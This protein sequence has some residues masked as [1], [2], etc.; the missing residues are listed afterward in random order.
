MEIMVLPLDQL[1]PAP[2]NP[3]RALKPGDAAFEKLK[4]SIQ[5]YS[6]IEPIIWNE[7]TGNIVGGHQRYAVLKDLGYKEAH[8]SVVHLTDKKEKALNIA[9][10]KIAGEWDEDLL[11][12]LLGEIGLEINELETGFDAGEID[13]LLQIEWQEPAPEPDLSPNLDDQGI[14]YENQFGVIVHCKTE[15][16]QQRIYEDLT[17]K[18]YAC[19]VVVV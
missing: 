11:T 4:R 19:K 13:S 15:Y 2:Y 18:G 7:R 1:N 14:A 12:S 16:E 6:Y 3:R 9:L 17:A 10:N 8:V 5:Q